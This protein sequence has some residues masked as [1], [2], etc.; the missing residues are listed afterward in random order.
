MALN[1]Q[2]I[3]VN[4]RGGKASIALRD[5]ERY[6]HTFDLSAEAPFQPGNHAKDDSALRHNIV[7]RFNDELGKFISDLDDWALTYITEHSERLLGKQL[8]REQIKANY[9]SNVK[10]SEG[11]PPLVKCK[12]NMPGSNKPTRCWDEEG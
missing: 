2:S 3:V 10:H 6:A 7:F 9:V 12:L 1:L 8:S 11:R 4:T 5:G